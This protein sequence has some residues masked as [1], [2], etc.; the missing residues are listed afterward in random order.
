VILDG[1]RILITG[2]ISRESIAF[3]VAEQAQRAGAAGMASTASCTRSR[4]PPRTR[5]AGAS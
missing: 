5:S 1:K 3:G 2:V 4:S